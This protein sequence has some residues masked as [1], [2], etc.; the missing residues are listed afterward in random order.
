MTGTLC[1]SRKKMAEKISIIREKLQAAAVTELPVLLS[2]YEPDE[3]AGVQAEIARA[4]K[5]ASRL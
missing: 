4:K 2:A 5:T 1:G 3:R